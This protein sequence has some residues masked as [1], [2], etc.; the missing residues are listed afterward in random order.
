M[1]SYQ[2][3][4]RLKAETRLELFDKYYLS[5]S[6]KKL[7][8]TRDFKLEL[9][10]LNPE[11]RHVKSFS[12]QWLAAAGTSVVAALISFIILSGDSSEGT[13]WLLL[14]TAVAASLLGVL[15]T[16]LFIMSIKRKWVLETRAA[17]HPLVEVPYHKKDTK[18]AKQFVELLQGAIEINIAE[19]GYNNEHLF[20]GEMRML[21][22]LAKNRI[23]SSSNY[24][25]AKKQMLEKN[26]H[27]G[28][29]S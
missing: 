2:F 25:R 13:P 28:L 5:V 14:G 16:T 26:G 9:A 19:K 11:V 27:M 10:I 8:G 1:T 7:N 20:A 17:H 23:L 22:R 18:Q 12:F 29:A 3:I 21:R 24:D 4:N 6:E 15:F